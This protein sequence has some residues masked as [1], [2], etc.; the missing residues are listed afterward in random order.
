MVHQTGPRNSRPPSIPSHPGILDRTETVEV[1]LVTDRATARNATRDATTGT[2]I[3]YRRDVGGRQAGR[4]EAPPGGAAPRTPP[5]VAEQEGGH[6]KG[7]LKAP[8]PM[9]SHSERRDKR[10]YYHFHMEYGYDTEEYRDLQYQIKDL[11]RRGHLRRY[12][13]DQSSL[14]DSRPPRNSSPRPKGPVEKQIDVIFGGPASSG[15]S[16]SARKAYT[17]SEVG[18]RLMHDEELDITFKSGG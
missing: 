2:S 5:T 15:D 1:L 12:I 11:I 7:L 18:K 8:N 14:P 6:E 3:H 10:R 4:D 9:K 16:S 17:Q 13:R